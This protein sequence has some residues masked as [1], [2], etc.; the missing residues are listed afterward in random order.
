MNS[1]F[2]LSYFDISEI[3]CDLMLPVAEAD[4]SK[5]DER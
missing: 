5:S 1:C 2:G 3:A 4:V